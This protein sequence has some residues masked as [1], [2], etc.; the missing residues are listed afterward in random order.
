MKEKIVAVKFFLFLKNNDFCWQSLGWRI[1]VEKLGNSIKKSN[2][3]S[4]ILSNFYN[5]LFWTV[6]STW[7][8]RLFDENGKFDSLNL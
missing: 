6:P 4:K 7:E 8:E 5:G 1:H 2:N 3:L